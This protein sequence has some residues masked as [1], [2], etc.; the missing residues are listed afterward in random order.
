MKIN[1]IIAIK[2]KILKIR[3]ESSWLASGGYT[4]EAL[5]LFKKANLLEKSLSKLYV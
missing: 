5:K 4:K 3:L 1:K 2:I